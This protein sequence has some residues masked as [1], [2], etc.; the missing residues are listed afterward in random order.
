MHKRSLL[1]IEHTKVLFI[2]HVKG[3]KTE[4]KR[5]KRIK[6]TPYPLF[7]LKTASGVYNLLAPGCPVATKS[8]ASSPMVPT[9]NSDDTS[10]TLA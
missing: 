9:G 10:G 2:I 7:V 5:V 4:K 3:T 8:E 6:V 1:R